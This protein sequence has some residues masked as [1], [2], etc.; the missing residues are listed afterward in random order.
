MRYLLAAVLCAAAFS[1]HALQ[2]LDDAGR[3]V[4]LHHP[5]RRIIVLSPDTVETLFALG[6]GNRVVGVISG[7]DYPSAARRLPVVGTA[8]GLDLE[9]MAAL[10]PDLIITW[11]QGFLRALQPLQ[12][13]GVPVFVTEPRHL[14]DV[15]RLMRRFGVLLGDEA[16]ADQAAGSVSAAFQAAMPPPGTHR[17]TRVFFELAGRPLM[18]VNGESWISEAIT[19]CGGVNVFANARASAPVVD[20]EAVVASNPDVIISDAPSADW[21]KA[22]LPFKNVNA[23]AHHAMVSINPDLIERASPRL[24]QGVK[25]LCAYL[26]N[27]SSAKNFL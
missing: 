19:R 11:G 8:S 24:P 22:W 16:G 17:V 10:Q 5:A 26:R 23:V 15:P 4:E 6:A 12:A 25:Q 9:R 13:M 1:A 2:C 21:R 27:P 14:A 20:W 3:M 7:S 18:T